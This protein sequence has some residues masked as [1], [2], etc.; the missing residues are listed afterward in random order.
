MAMLHGFVGFRE[1]RVSNPTRKSFLQATW[2]V[3]KLDKDFA[4]PAFG[5]S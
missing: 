4:L 2:P 3:W 1:T 5:C